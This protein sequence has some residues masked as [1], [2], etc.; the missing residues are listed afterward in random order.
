MEHFILKE[1]E[2][3]FD[4]SMYQQDLVSLFQVVTCLKNPTNL[5][6]IIFFWE[7]VNLLSSLCFK[8]ATLFSV[9]YK[10]YKFF[11]NLCFNEDLT[12]AYEVSDTKNYSS[13]E[14]V[15]LESTKQAYISQKRFSLK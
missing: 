5:G 13:F 3:C 12:N 4:I 2:N 14:D 1:S 10:Y 9:F 15:F 11:H 8:H 6:Y 7:R